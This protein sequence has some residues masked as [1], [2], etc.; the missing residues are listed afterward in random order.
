[1]SKR[2]IAI[3]AAAAAMVL[4]LLAGLYIYGNRTEPE[5]E[6]FH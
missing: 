1:M 2:K 4:A 5:K 3:F 6:S